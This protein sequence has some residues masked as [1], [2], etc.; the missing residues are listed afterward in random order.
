MIRSPPN[1][2]PNS[3]AVAVTPVRLVGAVVA[4]VVAVALAGACGRP[5]PVAHRELSG[6]V[7][8]GGVPAALLDCRPGHTDHVFVEV[9][10]SI[11]VLRFAGGTLAWNGIALGCQKLDRSWGGG[12]RRDGTAY[13]RGRLAFRCGPVAGDLTLDCG[14]ITPEEAA[15]LERNRSG[16]S[17][18]PPAPAGGQAGGQAGGSEEPR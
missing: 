10:T 11:G 2:W 1:V 5:E 15:S 4:V 18:A 8:V 17:E 3:I 9:D 14:Q 7:L 6:T 12:I 16:R 13:F